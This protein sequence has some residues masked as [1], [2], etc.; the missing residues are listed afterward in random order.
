MKSRSVGTKLILDETAVGGLT[1]IGGV[2]VSVDT[3]DFTDLGDEEGWKD[4]EAGFKDGGEVPISGY[5]DGDDE[6]QDK[7]YDLLNSGEKANAEIRFPAKIGKSWTFKAI[8]TGFETGAELEN[9]VSFSAT[10]KVCGKPT[11]G[12][13]VVPGG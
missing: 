3:Y 9:G 10:L 12:K 8:V 6:G 13:T 5:M 11:L 4:F 1:S 7:C 2:K